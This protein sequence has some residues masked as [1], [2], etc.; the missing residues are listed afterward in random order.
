MRVLIVDDEVFIR[1]GLRT[2]IDWGAAGFDEVMDAK[3]A[4]EAMEK[5]ELAM[6]D[7]IL[8]D[9]FMPEMSGLDFAKKMRGK[10]PSIRFVILTGYEKFEYAKEAIEIGVAKYLVKPIFPD[11]LKETVEELRDEMLLENRNR[12]WNETARQRLNEYKP[13][14]TEK[15]W[16]DLLSDVLAAPAEIR[17]RAS[18]ADIQVQSSFFCCLAVEIRHLDKV[19]QRYGERELPL[20]RFAIRNII[21]EI[22]LGNVAYIYDHSDT[23]LLCILSKPIDPE[24]WKVTAGKID[25]TIKVDVCMGLGKPCDDISLVR[26]SSL[27]ALDC[28]RYLAM[29]DQ[30]GFIRYEEIPAWKKDH[31]EYPYEEE[32]ILLEALRYRDQ[33]SDQ[34]LEPFI[35]KLKNQNPSPQMIHLI[36]VQLLGALYRLADEYEIDTIPTFNQSVSKLET[37]PSYSQIQ[38]LFLELFQ[39][40]VGRKSAHHDS[41]VSQLVNRAKQMIHDRYNDQALSVAQIAQML[42]ISPN[43]LSRIFHQQ[44]GRTCVEHIT[45]CRLVEAKKLLLFSTH[46]NYEIAEKVGYANAHYFSFMFKK[47]MG[48]SPSEFRERAGERRT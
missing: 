20:V 8:T 48:C 26:Q 1:D 36:S 16:S 6:P 29:L 11:E 13:I 22:H 45:E 28:V 2:L 33:V 17:E 24:E 25:E 40:I 9:I 5:I 4:M 27:E 47:N 15:F 31:V 21:E 34:V 32:K 44:T 35:R 41:F 12:N 3:N 10:Y 23:V 43:Y 14:I 7:L 46:K 30:S 37:L 42:C 19:F 18:A 38:Q 39:E